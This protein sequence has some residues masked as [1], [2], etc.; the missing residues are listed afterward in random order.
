MLNI[1]NIIQIIISLK[2]N[3]KR[4]KRKIQTLYMIFN[5]FFIREITSVVQKEVN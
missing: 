2:L 5:L 1:F 3:C 4:F